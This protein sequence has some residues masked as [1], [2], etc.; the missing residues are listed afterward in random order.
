MQ[1][2]PESLPE[3]SCSLAFLQSIRKP[4]RKSGTSLRSPLPNLPRPQPAP[5]A[6]LPACFPTIPAAFQEPGGIS[7][8]AGIPENTKLSYSLPPFRFFPHH[9][10]ISWRYIFQFQQTACYSKILLK[11]LPLNQTVLKCKEPSLC[12][13]CPLRSQQYFL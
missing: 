8:A 5:A 11:K 4:L 6:G 3:L 13:N 12:P 1:Y 2:I 7:A 9:H 10:N